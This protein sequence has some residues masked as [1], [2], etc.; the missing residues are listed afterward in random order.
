M[1][2]LMQIIMHV[3]DQANC[4]PIRFGWRWAGHST[5]NPSMLLHFA[6]SCKIDLKP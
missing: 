1:I 6:S 3:S 2:S 5:I 4:F